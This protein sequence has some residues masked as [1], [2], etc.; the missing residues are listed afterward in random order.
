VSDLAESNGVAHFGSIE[1]D[2]TFSSS[3][4]AEIVVF[5]HGETEWNVDGRIQ[6]QLD[7]ELND[8]GRQQAAAVA[9]RLSKE[10]KV[11]VVYSSDL[12]RALQSAQTIW[13]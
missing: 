7:V 13:P 5:R 3:S 8:V 11:S 2:S 10:P 12:K 1:V 6:G 9:A 4:Y